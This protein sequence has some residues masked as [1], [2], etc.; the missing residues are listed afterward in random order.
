MEPCVKNSR[1]LHLAEMKQAVRK[2]GALVQRLCPGGNVP[3]LI[4]S[5]GFTD[6]ELLKISFLSPIF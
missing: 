6:Y 3:Q 4:A 5:T 1:V 2:Y